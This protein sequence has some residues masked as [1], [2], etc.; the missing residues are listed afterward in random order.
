MIFWLGCAGKMADFIAPFV[1]KFGFKKA[2]NVPGS[3]SLSWP[4]GGA[5][6][7][8]S[9]CIPEKVIK[10]LHGRPVHVCKILTDLQIS[11]CEMHKNA[12]MGLFMLSADK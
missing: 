2:T 9:I 4:T 3:L 12:F 8:E 7:T 10:M 5:Y 6:N 1:E 11:G